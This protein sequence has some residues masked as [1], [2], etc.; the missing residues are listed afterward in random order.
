MI[1]PW[2]LTLSKTGDIYP[3]AD[4]FEKWIPRRCS[5]ES[6]LINPGSWEKALPIL[7]LTGDNFLGL[8]AISS[9]STLVRPV[10]QPE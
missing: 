8:V 1:N 5:T 9:V 6:L 7:L 10:A 3:V 4:S 2:F